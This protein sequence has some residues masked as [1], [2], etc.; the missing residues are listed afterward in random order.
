M[1]TSVVPIFRIFDY[2]K[3]IEFY[4]DWLGF[5]IDWEHRFDDNPPIS[6]QVSRD[7]IILHLSEHYGDCAPGSK[8]Y[9]TVDD[10]TKLYKEICSRPYQYN[11][12]GIEQAVWEAP[13]FEVIDPFSNKL[14]ITEEGKP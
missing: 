2:K 3:A 11:R 9:T 6:M 1:P 8:A 7:G 4:V 12:P 14:M 5:K 13:C 10:V